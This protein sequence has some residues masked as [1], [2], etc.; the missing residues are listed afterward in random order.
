MN[1]VDPRR[2][3]RDG[4]ARRGPAPSLRRAQ[5]RGH[6]RQRLARR[7]RPP[8]DPGAQADRRCVAPA[9]G[10]P[11][12]RPSPSRAGKPSRDRRFADHYASLDSLYF[13]KG[14]RRLER[15]RLWATG[16]GIKLRRRR[17]SHLLRPRRRIRNKHSPI[18]RPAPR[19]ASSPRALRR[20]TTRAQ[21]ITRKIPAQTSPIASPT[22]I[23]KTPQPKFRPR[24]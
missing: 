19:L 17:G 8:L 11:R 1:Q 3:P 9:D 7:S 21:P 23:P 12:P 18:P 5:R 20:A 10:P 2:R 16:R 22:Q 6:P 14:E 24:T 4:Y 15:L 13:L